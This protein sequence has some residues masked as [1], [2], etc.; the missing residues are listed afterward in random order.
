MLIALQA[1]DGI[2]AGVYGVVIVALCA[3]LTRGKGRFNA[4]Q[5]LIATAL[6]LGGVLGPLGAGFLVEHLGFAVAFDVFAAVAA[7]AAA[8][9]IVFM[10]ETWTAPAAGPRSVAQAAAPA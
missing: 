10:P 1:L 7:L 6:S 3:D 4:L 9:F 8:L 2:G 5:G